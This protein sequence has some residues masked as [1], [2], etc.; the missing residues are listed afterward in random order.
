[1]YLYKYKYKYGIKGI[2][3]NR[4]CLCNFFYR[5]YFFFQFLILIL[6]GIEKFFNEFFVLFDYYYDIVVKKIFIRF[7]KKGLKFVDLKEIKICIVNIVS[8][9]GYFIEI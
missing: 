4:W 6:Q 2:L 8:E 3:K 5:V 1:M 9:Q 7:L